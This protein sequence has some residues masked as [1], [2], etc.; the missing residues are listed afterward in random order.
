MDIKQ[1]RTA[2]YYKIAPNGN[3]AGKRSSQKFLEDNGYWNDVLRL[4]GDYDVD[5]TTRLGI[6]KYGDIGRCGVCGCYTKYVDGKFRKYCN[7]HSRT[8]MKGKPAHNRKDVDEARII[9]CYKNGMSALQISQQ[10]WC[11]VS[12]VTVQHILERNGVRI[13]SISEVLLEKRK[14]IPEQEIR[15]FYKT[16]NMRQTADEFGVSLDRLR[17]ILDT[18]EHSTAC[19]LAHPQYEI[20][21]VEWN[22]AYSQ[23]K[24]IVEIARDYNISAH[25]V[26]KHIE[27]LPREKLSGKQRCNHPIDFTGLA[28]KYESGMSVASLAIEYDCHEWTIHDT[29]T[30]LGLSQKK[31]TTTEPERVVQAMLTKHNIDFVAHDRTQIKPKELDIFILSH[32]LAIEINGLYWHSTS[33]PKVDRRHIDKFEQCREA[34]IKLLQFTDIMILNQ[35]ELVESMILSKLGLLPNK[36]MARK[37]DIVQLD[38]G[39]ANRLFA[40][41]HY[42]GATSN[43]AKCV[44]LRYDN[45]IVAV[46]AYTMHGSECRIER[47]VCE[48]F[49]N[50][51]GGYSRLE[52][53]VVKNMQPKRLVTFSLGL[54][55]DGSLY[56]NNGYVTDGYATSPEFYVTDGEEMYNRQRFMKSKM[57]K[58]FGDGFDPAKTEWENII[59]NGLM[60]F[61][62][63]GITKWV[64]ELRLP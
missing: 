27:K 34:G 55:S 53:W 11:D 29:L 7:E 5:I 40:Q 4:T 47:F 49:T 15:E 22:N 1:E 37:C 18:H 42:Q 20:E 2:L 3:I 28:V 21:S 50:V 46:L 58:L 44:G 56:K 14:A 10:D 38:I 39:P 16:A 54:I 32:N 59:S 25:T 62:G 43:R 36:I 35:P 48:L 17:E 57:S 61:F 6:L 19:K 9:E 13:K 33:V 30:K 23:G 31:D 63:A 52:S 60:L 26:G 64:K 45:R 12:H 41:W 8:D 24:R 51:V